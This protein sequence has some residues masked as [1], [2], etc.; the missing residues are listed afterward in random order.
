MRKAVDVTVCL[1]GVFRQQVGSEYRRGMMEA[2]SMVQPGRFSLDVGRVGTQCPYLNYKG[3]Q[4]E[5][6][7]D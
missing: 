1:I 4:A 3:Q 2:Y 5:L 6:P 7:L